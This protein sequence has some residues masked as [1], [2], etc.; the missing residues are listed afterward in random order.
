MSY[1]AKPAL[2]DTYTVVGSSTCQSNDVGFNDSLQALGPVYQ[3]LDSW[4]GKM[5]FFP[6]GT[7][8]QVTNGQYALPGNAQ[9]AG[10]YTSNCQYASTANPDG[11]FTLNGICQ[12]HVLSGIAL[13]ENNTASPV[14][15]RVFPGSGTIQLSNVGVEVQTLTTDQSG[16]HY[17]IC[18]GQGSGTK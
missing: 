5:Q 15:W 7:V 16:T 12:G 4:E 8:T 3:V 18:Q 17:R 10:A 1:A 13:G 2:N 9:P 11:S 6:N 14:R